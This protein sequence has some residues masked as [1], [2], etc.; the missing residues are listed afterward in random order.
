MAFTSTVLEFRYLTND[1]IYMQLDAP[2]QFT[3]RAGQFVT[4][5][6]VDGDMKRVKSYSVLNPPSKKGVLEFCI[7]LVDGGF[8]SEVFKR[9]KKGDQFEVKGPFGNFVF[10]GDAGVDEHWFIGTGTGIV[11]FYSMLKEH[12]PHL[13]EKKFRFIA[14]YRKKENVLFHDEFLEL[15]QQYPNFTY[16]PTLSQD[17][18][19][20]GKGRVQVHLDGNLQNI[21]FYICGLKEMVLETRELLLSKGVD[22]KHIEFERY[23]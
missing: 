22:M 9:T 14:G 12:L 6:I 3:F 5:T 11:P 17:M 10:D 8:A 18:W 21:K 4:L 16:R 19:E 7:K 15:A 2:E 23:T 1:V 13:Q 20:H